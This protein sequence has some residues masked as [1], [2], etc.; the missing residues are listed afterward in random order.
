MISMF[1]V[2][3]Y[4]YQEIVIITRFGNLKIKKNISNICRYTVDW[5][6]IMMVLISLCLWWIFFRISKRSMNTI[7][8]QKCF[9]RMWKQRDNSCSEKS[10]SLLLVHCTS[11]NFNIE[12]WNFNAVELKWFTIF[13]YIKSTAIFLERF[14][15]HLPFLGPRTKHQS[16][17]IF[18]PRISD[19]FNASIAA[20]ASLK[21]SYSTNA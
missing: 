2:V 21:V 10:K 17:L 7:S 8:F 3:M 5:H 1:S 12:S 13:Y 20:C 4:K 15:T 16:T 9:I 18:W 14:I 11:S 19:P 6:I